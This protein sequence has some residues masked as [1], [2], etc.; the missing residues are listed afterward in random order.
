MLL[1]ATSQTVIFWN[2]CIFICTF[3]GFY[4]AIANPVKMRRVHKIFLTGQPVCNRKL[5]TFGCIVTV[6][7]MPASTL[8]KMLGTFSY[9]PH[10][11]SQCT[12]HIETQSSETITYLFSTS[13]IS[14]WYFFCEMGLYIS[15]SEQLEI[16]DPMT[17]K[18][19]VY[20]EI[21]HQIL[22][23]CKG[24]TL[25]IEWKITRKWIRDHSIDH[26]VGGFSGIGCF[27]IWNFCRY[28]ND[29]FTN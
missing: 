16:Y 2:T 1:Y 14:F 5:H 17:L 10:D 25:N 27:I 12:P 26:G 20:F 15:N 3:T 22:K 9:S 21:I 13:K 29:I 19:C 23:R 7:E 24:F 18:P 11:F 4:L 8:E 28:R 6:F